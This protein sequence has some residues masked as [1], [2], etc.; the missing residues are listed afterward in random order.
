MISSQAEF[1]FSFQL[2]TLCPIGYKMAKQKIAMKIKKL[3]EKRE[4][5]QQQLADESGLSLVTI[6][7]IEAGMRKNP[8]LSTRKKLA[9]ALGVEITE[10]LD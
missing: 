1:P 2:D 4:W 9:K 7:R 6:G 10:L 5:T 8:D 3:R